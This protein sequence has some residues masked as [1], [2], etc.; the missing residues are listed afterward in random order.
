MCSIE[1]DVAKK[2][3]VSEDKKCCKCKTSRSTILIRHNELCKECFVYQMY[4]KYKTI[5]TKCNVTKNVL[6][7]F[8]GGFC[9]RAMVHLSMKP[10][11]EDPARRK[12][13]DFTMC[14]VDDR[15]I[16]DF[17]DASEDMYK[18]LAT[19][20][21]AQFCDYAKSCFNLKDDEIKAF[22]I[23][24][25]YLYQS[26][27]RRIIVEKAKEASCSFALFGD[28]ATKTAANILANVS[29]GRGFSLPLDTGISD[30]SEQN[31]MIVRP[32][33]DHIEKEISLYCHFEG[34]KPSEYFVKDSSTNTH[35]LTMNFIRGLDKDFPSTVSTVV[36]TGLKVTTGI[37]NSTNP[38]CKFC[39]RKRQG[40][41]SEWSKAIT[42]ASI[43]KEAV[44]NS[45]T[46]G[47]VCFGCI[48]MKK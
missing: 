1:E 43:S 30:P 42:I 35:S 32:M 22:L 27:I 13:L 37:I 47:D 23:N 36:R 45:H 8:S 38:C 31:L 46:D 44:E 9:S 6:I 28:S 40:N 16:N 33:S 20:S 34:L 24:N 41:D 10:Y 14:F 5:V 39:G 29:D 25:P 12:M 48:R 2:L 18:E 7:A 15:F 21:K 3:H 26:V 11:R 17:D 19:M 4:S